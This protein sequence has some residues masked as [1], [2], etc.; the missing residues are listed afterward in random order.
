MKTLHTDWKKRATMQFPDEEIE[1]AFMDQ[2]YGFIQNKAGKLLSD[3]HRLGFEI[4][5]KND[6]STRMVGI[7]AFRSDDRLLYAPCFFINGEIKGTDLLYQHDRK[8]F[9]PLTERWVDYLLKTQ[10]P[11]RGGVIKAMPRC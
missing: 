9:V 2:A 5:Y 11:S 1:R 10:N 4:V 3:P 6:N 8:L 7:F